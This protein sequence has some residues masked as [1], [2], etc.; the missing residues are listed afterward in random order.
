MK[1]HVTLNCAASLDGIIGRPGVRIRFSNQADKIRVHRLRAKSDGIM[2]GINTVLTDDP[3]L[4]V[5]YARG[6]NPV[7][8][9]VDSRARTP[10]N[11]NVLDKSSKTV[12]AVSGKA[13]E[14]RKR[15]LREKADVLVAGRENVNLRKLMDLLYTRNIKTLL[16]EGG[17]TLNAGMLENKLVDEIYI[18]IAPSIMGEG[19]R[20]VN[21]KLPGKIDLV[22]VGSRTLGDQ[23]VLHYTV[24]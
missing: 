12:I 11:S 7:R 24:K 14:S 21:K 8:I 9:V 19:I 3:H 23:I 13:P 20:W 1:P 15:R 17:G 2:V 16:L 18:T 4:T 6:S 5:K 10:L 22:Y